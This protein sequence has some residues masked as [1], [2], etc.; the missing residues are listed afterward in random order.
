MKKT[1]EALNQ[2]MTT[3]YQQINHLILFFYTLIRILDSG[4]LYKEIMELKSEN[5][6]PTYISTFLRLKHK[7][8]IFRTQVLISLTQNYVTLKFKNRFC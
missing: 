2:T 6:R 1:A 7:G 3:N 8:I 4:G 5:K